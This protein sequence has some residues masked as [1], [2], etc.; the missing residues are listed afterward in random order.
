MKTAYFD[1][2]S[3]ISGDMCLG[4]LVDAGAPLPEIEKRLK[5][6]RLRGFSLSARK[7]T[8]AGFPATKIDVRLSRP[9]KTR[10]AEATTWK[11]V[12]EI[13]GR[14][15]LPA[16]VSERT[17]AI[18]RRLFEAEAAAHGT[19]L[20]KAHLHELGAVDC[21]VDIAGTLTAL[22]ILGVDKIYSSALNLGS[23]SVRTVHGLLPVPAPAT[24]ELVKGI[25]V[26]SSGIDAELATPTGAAII[27]ALAETFGEMPCIV[28]E[29]VGSGA[30]GRDFTDRPNILRV[31]I[32]R[33]PDTG[34]DASVI[35]LE[36]NIDDMNPQ[37]FD[38]LAERLFRKGALDVY[39]EQT[40]MKKMRP[41]VKLT[42]LC[43]SSQLTEIAGEIFRETTSIGVRYYPASRITL[44]REIRKVR[45]KYGSVRVKCSTFDKGLTKCMPEYEDCRRIAAT[46]DVPIAAV[47][48]EAR[49]SS[50]RLRRRG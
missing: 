4:A 6:L 39:L 5:R 17:L 25:P 29:A 35:V 41:A 38:Y 7:V 40:V 13:I 33:T 16:H 46:R 31:F 49:K 11:S 45:T 30:G 36:T 10:L 8:R 27:T 3:G 26:Y 1:C 23:G 42:V 37:V 43:G 32:G 50:E 48:E 15:A 47:M 2:S 12:R 44:P 28:P 34:T 18:F 21:F 20:R 24:A 19:S 9:G 14:S 22:D